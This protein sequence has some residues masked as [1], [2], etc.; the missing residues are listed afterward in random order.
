MPSRITVFES[1]FLFRL[2]E[3]NPLERGNKKK[4]RKE[5]NRWEQKRENGESER[6]KNDRWQSLIEIPSSGSSSST[7]VLW[8]AVQ[9][10]LIFS[11]S[12]GNPSIRYYLANAPHF[13]WSN[14]LVLLSLNS[15]R[16]VL[17]S[18]SSLKPK[19]D[20][21]NNESRLLRDREIRDRGVI[22]RCGVLGRY[23]REFKKISRNM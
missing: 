16:V 21:R 3:R 8:F 10:A 15:D 1:F 22:S 11:E 13:R 18:L 20:F 4:K 6:R 17:L 14:A 9:W 19:R 2:V 23:Q 7:R 5:K 12:L